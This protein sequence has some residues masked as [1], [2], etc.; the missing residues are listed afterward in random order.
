MHVADGL[1]GDA[2]ATLAFS[3]DE[4]NEVWTLLVCFV[5]AVVF[6]NLVDLI[7]SASK[8]NQALETHDAGQWGRN[9]I[10]GLTMSIC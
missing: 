10:A 8:A 3:N 9:P 6:I 5:L 1:T 7:V 4:L 2:A